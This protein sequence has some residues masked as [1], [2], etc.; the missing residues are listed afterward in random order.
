MKQRSPRPKRKGYIRALLLILFVW[1]LISGSRSL[2]HSPYFE[3]KPPTI[4]LAQ[5]IYWNLSS[6]LKIP[7]E[8]ASGLKSLE[9]HLSDGSKELKISPKNFHPG[10][11]NYTL[12]LTFPKLGLNKEIGLLK[13]TV[14]ATDTSHW[15]FFTGN[16]AKRQAIIHIDE[17]KPELFP[18]ISSYGIRKGGA[19]LAIFKAKDENLKDL[20][21]QTNF[22]K[23][24]KPVPFH[25][26][27]YYA[28]LVAWPMTQKHFFAKIIAIDKA[29]NQAVSR[30][31]FFLKNKK[32][33]TSTIEA[34][35]RF[36]NGKI[37]DLA[38]DRP[39]QTADLTPAQKL[40]FV[41]ATYRK[42]N[43][44]LIRKITSKVDQNL[45]DDFKLDPFYP[46]K[47][48]KV[49][50]TFGDHRFYKYHGKIISEAYH[51]GLDLASTRQADILSSN[52]GV[53]VF[54]NYNGIY[55][56]NLIIY[57]G[58]GL[59]SLY[60]HCSVLLVQEG[61]IV[62]PWQVVAKS[63]ATGLALG[64]HLHFSILIQGIFVRPAEWMDSKWMQTNITDVIENA[65]KM[66]DRTR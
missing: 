55:G 14:K 26:K 10:V 22:G 63:G 42:E 6:P 65:K 54:A 20:Y 9:V 27:G 8:D 3:K 17:K 39:K 41:N 50:A 40:N 46:Q 23:R 61:D 30:L 5:E 25:K 43:N 16:S 47:N 35:D 52:K 48:A 21:I 62:R 49:V 24:F 66:I 34:K 18:L 44:S 2:L 38:E 32:Y 59:Y 4:H 7:F 53:V 11:K 15:N 31:S 37:S 1:G 58:L 28:V 51:L 33:R 45:L 19:A 29:G 36:I 60:G 57:H 13:L 12:D 56:N 64:D